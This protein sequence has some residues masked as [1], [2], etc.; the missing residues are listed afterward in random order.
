MKSN[1]QVSKVQENKIVVILV[2]NQR[3]NKE[4]LS[5][6]LNLE[7]SLSIYC[8]LQSEIKLKTRKIQ[9]PIVGEIPRP[10]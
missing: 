3:K 9:V 7:S 6:H 1:P 10:V 8:I 5:K 2:A 4:D